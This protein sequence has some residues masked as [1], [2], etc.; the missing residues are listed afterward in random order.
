M[1]EETSESHRIITPTYELGNM[2]GSK[3]T[4]VND[5]CHHEALN[6]LGGPKI[7]YSTS[8]NLISTVKDGMKL[9]RMTV[10]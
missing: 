5:F 8:Y 4:A 10:L 3:G 6:Q 2:L 1:Y 9:N 7:I